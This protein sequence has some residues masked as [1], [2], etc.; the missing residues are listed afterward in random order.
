[1][2]TEIARIIQEEAPLTITESTW[3]GDT[4]TIT[5]SNWNGSFSC[6]WRLSDRNNVR[7]GCW[8]KFNFFDEI[9]PLLVGASLIDC[10]NQSTLVSV[11][12]L[13]ALSNGL[14][15]EVFSID[16]F[17]PWVLRLP[18]APTYTGVTNS[19]GDYGAIISQAR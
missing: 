9:R 18:G 15:L 3:D 16:T 6:G 8:D 13:F 11:D 5:G 10:T 19:D 1:M 2:I 14:F 4:L 17:E 7:F 12:P